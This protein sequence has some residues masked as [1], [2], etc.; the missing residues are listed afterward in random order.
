MV[1]FLIRDKNKSFLEAVVSGGN[2]VPTEIKVNPQDL[3][4]FG[5]D[6]IDKYNLL[7]PYAMRME[8]RGV[9]Y[10]LVSSEEELVNNMQHRVYNGSSLTSKELVSVTAYLKK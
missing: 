3:I 2:L 7:W 4:H 1:K 10:L 8:E 9:D 5:T 6:T